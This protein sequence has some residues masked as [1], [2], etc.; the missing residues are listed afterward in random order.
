MQLVLSS[1][2]AVRKRLFRA[3][4]VAVALLLMLAAS[5]ACPTG[6]ANCD[7]GDMTFAAES[8]DICVLGCGV[9]LPVEVA[10][11][12]IE[13]VTTNPRPDHTTGFGLL[14]QR[15]FRPPRTLA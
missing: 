7:M 14:P 8:S 4:F 12:F 6:H 3:S 15:T 11:D 2:I 1:L 9:L 10:P 13:A 5:T